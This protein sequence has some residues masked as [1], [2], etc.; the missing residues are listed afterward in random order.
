M[1]ST[2]VMADIPIYWM[3]ESFS[4]LTASAVMILLIFWA[5]ISIVECI[6]LLTVIGD[7]RL[8]ILI[9]LIRPFK[10]ILLYEITTSLDVCVRQYLLH[11]LVKYSI[12]CGDTILY[13]KHIFDELDDWKTHL[14]YL[15]DEGKC[16]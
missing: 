16:R 6:S 12:K 3:M 14:C 1:E 10:V 2:V 7:R 5:Y 13:D 4:V 15:T 9:G 8:K 11:C